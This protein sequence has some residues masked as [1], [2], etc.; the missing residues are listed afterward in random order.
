MIRSSTWK[1]QREGKTSE[2]AGCLRYRERAREPNGSAK[3]WWRSLY[4]D[5]P[6]LCLYPLR[7]IA[8]VGNPLRLPCLSPGPDEN[9]N[10]NV[11]SA[12]FATRHQPTTHMRDIAI[13]DLTR[14]RGMGRTSPCS[15]SLSVKGN[16][17]SSPLMCSP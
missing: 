16:Q 9:H 7:Q 3:G 1:R 4:V 12:R 17:R 6:C 8:M 11:P 5:S 14:S 15:T 10:P 2:R 13:F